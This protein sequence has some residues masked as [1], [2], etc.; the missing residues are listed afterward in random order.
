[1]L[2]GLIVF[3]LVGLV[4]LAFGL[5]LWKKQKIGLIHEYHTRN[6]KPEDI[7]AY[8]RLM[9]VALLVIGA[10]CAVTGVTV[11][12][13]EAALGWLAF[14]AGFIVGLALIVRAQKKYN[15]GQL[16]S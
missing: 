2:L 10:G 5:A 9:G 13:L 11:F 6:V 4:C 1:M 15:G 8:T 7:P 14:P 3:L 16:L 12:I